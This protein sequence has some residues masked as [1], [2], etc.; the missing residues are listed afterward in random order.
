[1]ESRLDH[2]RRV[3][4][5]DRGSGRAPEAVEGPVEVSKSPHGTMQSLPQWLA[6]AMAM[7]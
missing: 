3:T 1:V 5:D 6:G 2:R 7:R 4:T